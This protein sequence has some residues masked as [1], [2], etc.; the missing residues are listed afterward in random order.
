ME[1]GEAGPGPA[2]FWL[3]AQLLHSWIRKN[4]LFERARA[5]GVQFRFSAP[6]KNAPA[7]QGSRWTPNRTHES[8]G[9]PRIHYR[10]REPSNST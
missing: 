3:H 2:P 10:P 6:T 7:R 5:P 4:D 1:R 9:A 8:S